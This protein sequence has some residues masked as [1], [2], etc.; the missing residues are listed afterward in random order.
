[1]VCI[2]VASAAESSEGLSVWWGELLGS[3]RWTTHRH[4]KTKNLKKGCGETEL[5][6]K[7]YQRG[8]GPARP[9]AGRLVRFIHK[10]N[11]GV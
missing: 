10:K 11:D 3:R 7:Q 5:N 6:K 8:G 1:M 9:G 4:R 2:Y